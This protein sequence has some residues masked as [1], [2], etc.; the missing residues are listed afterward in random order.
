MA[1]VV[2]PDAGDWPAAL[3]FLLAGSGGILPLRDVPQAL[4][5]RPVLPA[6]A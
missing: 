3:V 1:R 5:P 4:A 6:I 2:S